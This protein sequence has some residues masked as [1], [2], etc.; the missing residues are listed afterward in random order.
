MAATGSL[1]ET[2]QIID[3]IIQKTNGDSDLFASTLKLKHIPHISFSQITSIE[4]CPY[5]YYLQ[6]VK[7]LEPKPVPVY[8]AKGKL[9]H[10]IIA[11][12]YDKVSNHEPI[13]VNEFYDLVDQHF[14]GEHNINLKNAICTHL[15]NLWKNCEVIA[16]E[17]Q[18]VMDIDPDLPP[19][20][21]VIDLILKQNDRLIIIDH[22]T[23]HD[24]YQPDMLQM[25]IYKQYIKQQMHVEDCAFYYDHYRWVNNLSRIRKPAIYRNEI[26]LDSRNWECELQRIKHGYTKIKKINVMNYAQKDGECFRC[27]YRAVCWNSK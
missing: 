24:F 18:F 14:T 13:G 26:S 23:G 7:L 12:T 20:V 3:S 4:F 27:P 16:I 15:N 25:A 2:I 22:K 9:L 5:Q 17:K 8:F 19:C 1:L 11:S 21:G 6:Y 10:R